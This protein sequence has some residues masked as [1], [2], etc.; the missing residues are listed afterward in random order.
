MGN[1]AKCMQAFLAKQPVY[2]YLPRGG[3]DMLSSC[4]V[5]ILQLWYLPWDGVLG[6]HCLICPFQ[7]SHEQQALLLSTSA[8]WGIGITCRTGRQYADSMRSFIGSA[9]ME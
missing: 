9:G 7:F 4:Y 2:S 1:P 5:I 3:D 6:E 8:L